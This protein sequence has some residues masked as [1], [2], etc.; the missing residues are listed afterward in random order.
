LIQSGSN[1]SSWRRGRD[2]P[3]LAR[4]RPARERRTV[5]HKNVQ[6]TAKVYAH[7]IPSAAEQAARVAETMR[8]A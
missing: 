5:G 1:R 6:V 7:A 2:S 4:D 8:L 3:L